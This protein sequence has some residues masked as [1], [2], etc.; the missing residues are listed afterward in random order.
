MKPFTPQ[1]V[2]FLQEIGEGFVSVDLSPSA[3]WRYRINGDHD[4][5]V[6]WPNA[7]VTFDS[8]MQQRGAIVSQRHPRFSSAWVVTQTAKAQL[9]EQL[10]RPICPKCERQVGTEPSRKSDASKRFFVTHKDANRFKC[11]G[12]NTE[13]RA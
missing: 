12:S 2:R 4:R 7:T 5:E 9:A 13:V 3:T 1:Q 11:E 8:L 10:S 6:R